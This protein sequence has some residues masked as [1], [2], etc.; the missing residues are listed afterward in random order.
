MSRSILVGLGRREECARKEG[1]YHGEAEDAVFLHQGAGEGCVGF[2]HV[3]AVLLV[4][5]PGFL[6]AVDGEAEGLA[7][8]LGHRCG[9]CRKGC[10]R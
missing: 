3:G 5:E 10:R 4:A 9:R 2:Q 6:E 1:D 7:F 8:V